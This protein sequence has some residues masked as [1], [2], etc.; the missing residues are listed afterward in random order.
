MAVPED[1]VPIKDDVELFW[2]PPQSFPI[3]DDTKIYSSN[4]QIIIIYSSCVVPEDYG[5]ESMKP[6]LFFGKLITSAKL[7]WPV[8]GTIQKL[9]IPGE[10]WIQS[11]SPEICFQINKLANNS[12]V[13]ISYRP[14]VRV[15][16]IDII[17]G[18]I[19]IYTTNGLKHNEPT[20]VLPIKF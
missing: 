16:P 20:Y 5:V 8:F 14:A 19:A 9:P 3:I 2:L 13:Y 18:E 17:V 1:S 7:D 4:F 11:L 6:A 12:P 10:H 15:L